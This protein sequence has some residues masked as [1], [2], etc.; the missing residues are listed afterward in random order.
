MSQGQHPRRLGGVHHKKQIVFPRKLPETPDGKL[1][2]EHVG[3]MGADNRA[4]EWGD[5]ATK[6]LHR[7]VVVPGVTWATS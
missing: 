5:A 3:G 6:G 7:L 1:H 4:G 2:A